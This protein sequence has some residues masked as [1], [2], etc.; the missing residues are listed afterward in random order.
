MLVEPDCWPAG[1]S[2]GLP[3]AAP[4]TVGSSVGTSARRAPARSPR[5][6]CLG[7]CWTKAA[8]K[9]VS[10]PSR[11]WRPPGT[12]RPGGPAP[13]AQGALPAPGPPRRGLQRGCAAPRCSVTSLPVGSAQSLVLGAWG[14]RGRAG[15]LRECGAALPTTSLPYAGFGERHGALASSPVVCRGQA[16]GCPGGGPFLPGPQTDDA[17][18]LGHPPSLMELVTPPNVPGAAVLFSSLPL[19]LSDGA[20]WGDSPLVSAARASQVLQR[21]WHWG[22]CPLERAPGDGDWRP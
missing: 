3:T 18:D 4:R 20:S 13:G 8:G 10:A 14:S 9:T 2:T 21:A 7:N 1:R 19:E 15:R 5:S 12:R 16:P 11:C 22:P 6:P 17:L